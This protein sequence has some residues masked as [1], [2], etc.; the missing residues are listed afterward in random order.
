MDGS[1]SAYT[2]RRRRKLIEFE[3]HWQS[4][5]F[6]SL[7]YYNV[8][9]L[10]NR[11]RLIKAGSIRPHGFVDWDNEICVQVPTNKTRPTALLNPRDQHRVI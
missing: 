2:R 3:H 5:L 9:N 4:I 7:G 11:F 8:P 6:Q 10:L 1:D